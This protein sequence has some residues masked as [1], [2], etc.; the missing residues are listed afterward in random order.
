MWGYK[1]FLTEHLMAKT[2]SIASSDARHSK[3]M[4]QS[5]WNVQT[6]SLIVSADSSQMQPS[7]DEWRS[8]EGRAEKLIADV[9]WKMKVFAPFVVK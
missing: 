4:T 9:W 5:M 6:F 8:S 3:L 1:K 2:D 7:S